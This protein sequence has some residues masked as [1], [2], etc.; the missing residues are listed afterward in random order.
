MEG[1]YTISELMVTALA[2]AIKNGDIIFQGAATPM[3]M[4]AIELARATHAKN[5][6]Y[7]SALGI[8]PAEPLNF[9]A[10]L[11]EGLTEVLKR[12]RITN[13]LCGREMWNVFGKLTLEF[14]RPAQ[15]DKYWNCNNSVLFGEDRNFQ[16]PKFRFP[17]GMAVSDSLNLLERAV[18]YTPSH[19]KRTFVEKVDFLMVKGYPLSKWREENK[20]GKGP[21]KM[22]TNLCVFEPD[23]ETSLMKIESIHPGVTLDQVL[24][25]TGFKPL[26]PNKI[27]ETPKPTKEQLTLLREKIDAIGFR[28]L[29]FPHLRMQVMARAAKKGIKF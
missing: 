25:K 24:E 22:V 7:F 29:E 17:G 13:Y 11:C 15:I 3:P 20:M 6:V 14:L 18:L 26:I 1:E 10:M 4:V 21:V 19:R 16:K 5:T 2:S 9:E 12:T 28:D 27:P 8:S 23:P